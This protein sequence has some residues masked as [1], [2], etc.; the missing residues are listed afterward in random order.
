MH[1]FGRGMWRR[2]GDYDKM[3]QQQTQQLQMFYQNIL[4]QKQQ[5][6]QRQTNNDINIKDE[7]NDYD[8]YV[9]IEFKETNDISNELKEECQSEL[10]IEPNELKECQTELNI[11]PNELKECQT[12]LNIEPNELKECQVIQNEDHIISNEL[13]EDAPPAKKPK[14]RKNKKTT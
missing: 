4:K 2:V 5:H 14:K 8:D 3:L 9:E 7:P 12:E 6:Y 11:E 10:N 13:K 1:N